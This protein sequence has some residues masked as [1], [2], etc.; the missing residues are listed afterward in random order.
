MQT[1][2]Q[3][4]EYDDP[5]R[6]IINLNNHNIRICSHG[7]VLIMEHPDNCYVNGSGKC[8]DNILQY[9]I[10]EGYLDSIDEILVIDSY[11]D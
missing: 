3:Y 11:V 4:D 6:K 9:M 8:R 10:K 5:Q 2:D 7:A 1:L